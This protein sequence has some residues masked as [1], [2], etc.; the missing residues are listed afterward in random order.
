MTNK[1]LLCL[2]ILSLNL[3]VSP[4]NPNLL[5]TKEFLDS[6]L[7]DECSAST[8][9]QIHII[10][11]SN[12]NSLV[13]S[14]ITFEQQLNPNLLSIVRYGYCPN[15]LIYNATGI[16]FSYQIFDPPKRIV[17]NVEITDLKSNQPIYYKVGNSDNIFNNQTFKTIIYNNNNLANI[18]IK[19][20]N[21]NSQSNGKPTTFAVFGDFGVEFELMF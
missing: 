11:G 8:P 4:V 12:P 17:H 1:L 18:G 9:Q 13:I 5:T 14:W 19:N 21:S 20:I 10:F 6:I 15:N 16:P 3:L 2:L 7:L